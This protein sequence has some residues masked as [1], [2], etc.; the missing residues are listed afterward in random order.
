MS[1]MV[2]GIAYFLVM[3]L[4]AGCGAISRAQYAF[5]CDHALDI[6][7][8]DAK[9]VEPRRI[10]QGPDESTTANIMVS[11]TT[12]TNWAFY[13]QAFTSK[14][15]SVDP[16]SERPSIGGRPGTGTLKFQ[17]GFEHLWVEM[18]QVSGDQVQIQQ[19]FTVTQPTD[20]ISRM[21]QAGWDALFR[22]LPPENP[23]RAAK[24]IF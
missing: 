17:R 1:R 23:L 14:G 7:P 8:A 3:C 13:T 2:F 16:A 15:W 18:S 4:L 22:F 5:D 10:Y 12:Q 11:G 6:H 20:H 9:E 19:H 21:L 24:F